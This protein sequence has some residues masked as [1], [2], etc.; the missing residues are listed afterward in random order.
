MK[1]DLTH[2]NRLLTDFAPELRH[3]DDFSPNRLNE[4][5][6]D[7]QLQ[8]EDWMPVGLA[9]MHKELIHSREWE[10]LWISTFLPHTAWMAWHAFNKNICH[11]RQERLNYKTL[12]FFGEGWLLYIHDWK[13]TVAA[14]RS[15]YV[16]LRVLQVL[17]F[18][19]IQ[20]TLNGFL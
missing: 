13:M 18:S 1:F 15:A 3:K 5:G 16:S 10:M 14:M 12:A 7:I 17:L 6:T 4:A 8:A 2:F 19:S 9:L 11:V 20:L